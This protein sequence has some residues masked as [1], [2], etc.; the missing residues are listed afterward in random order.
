MGGTVEADVVQ[1]M[2]EITAIGY[3]F[4]YHMPDYVD[5]RFAWGKQA[6]ECD[7]PTCGGFASHRGYRLQRM[8]GRLRNLV[9]T[10]P[11]ALCDEHH[12]QVERRYTER[13]EARAAG[14]TT[15]RIDLQPKP[16]RLMRAYVSSGWPP[17]LL[18][19]AGRPHTTQQQERR[20]STIHRFGK[21]RQVT[22]YSM[23]G[24]A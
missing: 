20:H 4:S 24:R 22:Y 10:T 18:K 15:P 11:A 6:A 9:H 17:N 21:R 19:M 5:R 23:K 7:F 12:G 16:A 3:G 14:W 1:R 2:D 8:Q 13:L